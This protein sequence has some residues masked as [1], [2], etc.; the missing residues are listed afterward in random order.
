MEVKKDD[1][2]MELSI[3]HKRTQIIESFKN[4]DN[5]KKIEGMFNKML[6]P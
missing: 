2:S 3:K 1:N 4:S 6:K 5:Q